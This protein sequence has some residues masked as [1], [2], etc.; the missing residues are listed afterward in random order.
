MNSERIKEIHEET[1]HGESISVYTALLKV[2]NECTQ[3]SNWISV[4]DRMPNHNQKVLCYR[5]DSDLHEEDISIIMF[6]SV[7]GGFPSA[8]TK[9]QPLPKPPK[10]KT[11]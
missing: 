4:E 7:A 6:G 9:W 10:N 2:W 5:P 1:A 11:L 3:E 8:V